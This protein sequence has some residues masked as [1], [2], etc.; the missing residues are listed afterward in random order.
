MKEEIWTN[1]R[2][3]HFPKQSPPSSTQSVPAA[4]LPRYL[5]GAGAPTPLH[6]GWHLF[7][8]AWVGRVLDRGD[9]LDHGGLHR[10]ARPLQLGVAFGREVPLLEVEGKRERQSGQEPVP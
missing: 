9:G 8:M 1:K 4:V 6:G 10:Q 7:A 3:Q 2:Q 5:I